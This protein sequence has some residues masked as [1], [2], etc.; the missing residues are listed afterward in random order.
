VPPF[1][2][3]SGL[4]SAEDAELMRGNG[5]VGLGQLADGAAHAAWTLARSKSP[6]VGPAEVTAA[7]TAKATKRARAAAKHREF[8]G[9]IGIR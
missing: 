9:P 3:A 7:R 8:R 5:A 6:L 2:D 4:E 1:P